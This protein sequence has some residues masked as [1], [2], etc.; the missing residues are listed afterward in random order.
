[1]D[2]SSQ[3]K[4]AVPFFADIAK[5]PAIND[6]VLPPKLGGSG[7]HIFSQVPVRRYDVQEQILKKN[8][9]VWNVVAKRRKPFKQPSIGKK[10]TNDVKTVNMKPPAKFFLSWLQAE[11]T[12]EQVKVFAK[13]QFKT[14]A[15]DVLKLSAEFP[16]FYSSFRITVSGVAMK[17]ASNMKYW[18]EGALVKK[19]FSPNDKKFDNKPPIVGVE[20][21]NQ[22][23]HSQS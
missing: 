16:E 4:P 12:L 20:I 15:V 18:P 3:P 8:D 17:N 22:S 2:V 19:F 11:I 21:P 14:E 7:R 13:Q 10:A 1:M 23:S 9:S 5:Q 6:K